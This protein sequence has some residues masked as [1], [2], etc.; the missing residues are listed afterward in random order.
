MEF[1]DF[2]MKK[3]FVKR[4]IP[5]LVYT[6]SWGGGGCSHTD[7]E[8]ADVCSRPMN[9]YFHRESFPSEWNG[10][11]SMLKNSSY[12]TIAPLISTTTSPGVIY[13]CG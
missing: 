13:A 7:K 3:A 2:H 4:E 5:G 10:F 1:T 6:A 11:L 9:G 8:V 12:Q